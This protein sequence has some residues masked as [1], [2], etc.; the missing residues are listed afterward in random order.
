M[1]PHRSRRLDIDAR[2]REGLPTEP[3]FTV[4]SGAEPPELIEIVEGPCKF[5]VDVR[6]GHKTGF[7]LDQRDAR[8]VVGPFANGREVLNCFSYT[9]GFGLYARVAGATN[10]TQLDVSKDALD[11]AKRNEELM[12]ICGTKMHYEAQDVFSF[13]RTCRDQGR[14]FDMI[15]LDPPKFAHSKSQVMKASRGY[16]DINLLAMK[17]LRPDGI[18]A[19]FSCSG[20][21]DMPL[22]EKILASAADDSGHAFQV[23]AMTGQPVDH[24]VDLSFPEGRYLKG[25]VLRRVS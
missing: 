4:L 24:P 3:T 10:V 19:S 18:L 17:L 25:L 23:V 20:A 7:Y 16:K 14:Q 11:L 1:R 5:L 12:H 9:G 13:L 21:I 8:R 15:I 22:F 6:K 2:T